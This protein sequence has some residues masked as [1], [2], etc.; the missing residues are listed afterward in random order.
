VNAATK[1]CS[2]KLLIRIPSVYCFRK[3]WSLP[4]PGIDST[5]DRTRPP[6]GRFVNLFT[7]LLP[8]RPPFGRASQLKYLDCF[9][10]SAA[11][12]G[13]V[14]AATETC[15]AKF[16]GK[17]FQRFV[18]YDN[19]SCTQETIPSL[20]DIPRIDPTIRIRERT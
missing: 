11:A 4:A 2:K 13:R 12:E 7:V 3:F 6:F 16:M 18:V 17:D 8:T 10:P 15:M 14:N 20:S 9:I 5:Q 1:T 19:S